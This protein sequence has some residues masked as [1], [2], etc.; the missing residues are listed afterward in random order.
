MAGVDAELD[1][2]AREVSNALRPVEGGRFDL[3]LPSDAAAYFFQREGGRP[4]YVIWGPGGELVDQSDPDLH[5]G[6]PGNT[7][8]GRRE[9]VASGRRR[10]DRARRPRHRRP[11][12]RGVGAC[13]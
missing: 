9:K 4:Y 7:A 13:S 10:R 5:V 1:G 12:A 3:E 6:R 8:D 11:A 2:Y